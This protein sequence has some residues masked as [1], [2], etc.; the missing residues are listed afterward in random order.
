MRRTSLA[1]LVVYLALAGLL[2]P[3]ESD[4]QQASGI[5]GTAR[6][7][8]GGVLPGV[9]VEAS[10]PALIEKDRVAVSDSE[11][12]YNIVDLR[13]GT[14][15]VIFTLP[16]FTT[17]RREGI[18]LSA[19]FTATVN[20]DLQ[21]GTVEETITVTGETPLVD[22]QNVRRQTVISDE[23]LDTLPTSTKHANSL[24]SLTLGLSGIADVA[25][26]Y[27]TQVG[28]TYHGKGGTRTQFDGMNAQNMSGNAGYTLNAALVQEMTLQSTGI[29]A[30]GNAEGVLINMIPK[31]GGNTFAGTVSGL[32][33][34]DDLAAN[35][36]TS[37]LR[38]RGLDTVN[39]PLKI[40][41]VGVTLG[42]PIKRDK[43][44]FFTAH[45]EWGNAH[46][47]AGFYWNKTQGTPFYTPDLERPAVR[48]Q[49]YESHA[50]RL[51]WQATEE[52]KFSF[53]ADVQDACICRTGTTV[54][55][56]GVGLAPEGTLAYHFRPTG[57]YQASWSAPV[58]NRLLLDGSFAA[59]INHWPQ[60]RS[61]GVEPHHISILEQSTGVRYNA[62]ETYDDPNVQER[63]GERFSV[64]YVTGSHALK[65]GAQD[66]QGI[67][68]A[69]R[70][71]STSGVSY[72]FNNGLPVSLTQY[73]TPYELQNRFKHDLGIYAQDQ[74]A[75]RRLTLN[76]G[77]RFDY[78]YGYVPEQHVLATPNGWLPE[79]RYDPVEGV[80]L[81]KDLSP[82]LGA[83]YDLFGDGRTAVKVSLGRYVGKTVVEI[84]NQNNPIVA[85]VNQVNR[86]WDDANRNFVP[87]CDLASRTANGECG[88]MLNQN[89]G[90]PV[91]TT[92]F[93]DDVLRGFGVRPYNWDFGAEVQR[94]IGRSMSVTA[95]YYRNWYGNFRVTDNQEV[96]P[97]DYSPYCVTAPGDARLPGGGGYQVCGLHDLNQNRVG[98]V[99]NLVR[100]ARDF[101]KQTQVSNFFTFGVDMRL[102]SGARFGGGVDT[103]R[104]VTDSCFVVD[105]PQQ[106][107][108]CRIEP[109]FSAN[110][111]IK[112][113]GSYPL[114]GDVFVSAV[115]Q[116]LPG[117]AFTAD[118]AAPLAAIQP[119]LGRPL[120]GNART[121]T[122]PL[123]TPQTEFEERTTR[124]DFR[125]AKIVRVGPRV[126][127]QANLD[128]Y[129]ALNSSSLLAVTN[130][131]GARWRVPTL[132]IE[133]RI[134]QFSAQ[135]NF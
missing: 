68:K 91:V 74:W 100:P 73:A 132:L 29:S 113:N 71:S 101:G 87:D 35:N 107:V 117:P 55:G 60:F 123:L 112:L 124:L 121:A 120:S 135:V 62:R 77:L 30:E 44:W 52:H 49:W 89:F 81:W 1:S 66:E 48:K 18:V 97:A 127:V 3:A 69:Y 7:A 39:K 5:A 109:P 130:A 11:G 23:M 54:A 33:T 50:A 94:Q 57:F 53:L 14:Y 83:A 67:L 43:L 103:G 88:P 36:L 45:R 104:T 58:T 15:T 26:I 102:A 84:A 108:N 72:T 4:A 128:L 13:P 133:P 86:A 64:S 21:V 90:S 25:G 38:A 134:V 28:G 40:Y 115:Y 95:G 82:R 75:I 92:R 56:S 17:F 10:S 93:S 70:S 116:N 37:E 78:F 85:S 106:L 22:T 122:V 51:T 31:E 110:T 16:G 99:N 61:P 114:P 32:Y 118:W 2:W 19:G 126:R 111:Q 129:N 46:Q 63:Y 59:N 47:M 76:L 80:P 42:G 65:F 24:L 6:D 34:N 96:T 8:S 12:R 131:Y 125:V 9:T 41:D 98:R 79:R 20:A 105:S 27:Q 119:S